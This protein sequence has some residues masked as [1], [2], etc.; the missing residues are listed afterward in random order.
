MAECSYR[1]REDGDDN[2]WECSSCGHEWIFYEGGPKENDTCYCPRCGAKIVRLERVVCDFE[3][4]ELKV[5][6]DVYD[7]D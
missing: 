5:M 3:S 2:V 6:G 1:L 7:H 4:G